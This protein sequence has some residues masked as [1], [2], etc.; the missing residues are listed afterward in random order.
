VTLVGS[1]LSFA[2]E[3]QLVLNNLVLQLSHYALVINCFHQRI[4][5]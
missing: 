2:N 1:F 4:S 5:M 3:L